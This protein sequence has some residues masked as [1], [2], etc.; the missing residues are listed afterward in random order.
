[1]LY[2]ALKPIVGIALHW[3][4]RSLIVASAERIPQD[5]PVFLAAN[6]PNSLTDAMVVGWIAP[7]R[8]RF[9]AKATLF[10][11]P[12]GA[13]FLR[14]VG[15][16]PLRR[17]ADEAARMSASATPAA[18]HPDG[19]APDAARNA[20][21]FSAVADAL[22]AQACMVIFPEGKTHDEPYMAPL[23]TGLARMALMARDERGVRGIRIV[24]VGLLFENKSQPRTRVLVQVGE[25]IDVDRVPAGV[26]AVATLTELID[27]RLRAVTLNFENHADAERIQLLGSTL[28]ALIE[29]S[30]SVDEGAPPLARTLSLVRRIE[31]AQRTI[32]ERRDKTLTARVDLFESRLRTFHDRLAREG[33]N[34]HDVRI[35]LRASLGVRFVVRELAVAALMFPIIAWGRLTHFVPIRIT[36][37]L[38]LRN[39]RALDEPPQ[40]TFILGLALVLATY[41][42]LGTVVGV[43]AGPW[44]A[45]AFLASLIPSAS[46]DLRYGDRLQRV[47]ARARAYRRLRAAPALQASLRDDADWLQSEA[48][49]LERV[50]AT[51]P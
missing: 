36:R 27:Q 15:V 37:V 14:R 51:T 16:V 50:A 12:I 47:L 28:A 35:D 11:N 3:Y 7:R 24:P 43:L 33:I 25:V 38:A 9:T 41:A 13:W 10:A 19:V 42:V 48:G 29:P 20:S 2:T 32:R 46:A 49:A 8:V 39:V 44:W 17:A 5:G 26:S 6:H 18:E 4:Y 30:T 22:A 23:R 31:R 40:R 1:M 34:V 21:A 45:L